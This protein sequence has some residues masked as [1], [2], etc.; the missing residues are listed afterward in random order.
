ME[1]EGQFA[2]AANGRTS[3]EALPN[4]SRFMFSPVVGLYGSFFLILA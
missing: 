1:I 4:N 2:K 3:S